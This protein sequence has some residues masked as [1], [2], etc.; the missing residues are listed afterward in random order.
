MFVIL[1]M[2]LISFASAIPTYK[3]EEQIDYKI[4]CLNDG[5]CSNESYCNINIESPNST[6]IV[7]NQNMT[8]NGS[9]HFYNLTNNQLGLYFVTGYCYDDRITEK[10]DLNYLVSL[11]GEAKSFGDLIG[12]VFLIISLMTLI[13]LIHYFKT[14]F[15]FEQYYKKIMKQYENRNYVKTTLNSIAYNSLK[16]AWFWYYVIMLLVL[17]LVTD[18]A[19]NFNVISIYYTLEIILSLWTWGLI[20]VGIVIF[21][22][23]QEFLVKLWEDLNDQGWGIEK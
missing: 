14:G 9:V 18:L 23:V 15:G 4:T 6:L 11:S 13:Y 2:F 10:I 8:N 5:Y 16:N 3:Y 12:S 1:G 22:Y 7:K 21:S 17:M 19:Y 20:L